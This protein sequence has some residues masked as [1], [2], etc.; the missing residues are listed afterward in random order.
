VIAAYD[1]RNARNPGLDQAVT[2]LRAWNGQMEKEWAAPFL[3]SLIYQH[4]RTA[5]AENAAPG[6]GAA[7]EFT[8]A[9]A[10]LEQLLR[11]RPAGWF[12]DYDETLLRALVDAVEEGMRIQGRDPKRWQ[13]GA[14]LSL[15]IN[16]PVTHQLP[17]IGPYFDIGKVPMSGSSTTIK[18]TTMTLAPSMRLNADAGDWDRSLLNIMTGQSGEVLSRHYK[19]QWPDYYNGQSYPMLFH[20]VQANSTLEFRP[21]N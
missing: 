12:H 17:W 18:Q 15:P 2:L 1:R 4:L 6:A 8:L 10:V 7:Y 14:F 19:D 9:P 13:Y 20:N 16:N 11:Q 5:V 21:L 3:I